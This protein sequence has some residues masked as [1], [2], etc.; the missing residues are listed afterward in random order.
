MNC[1]LRLIIAVSLSVSCGTLPL[2]DGNDKPGYRVVPDWPKLPPGYQFGDVPGVAVDSKGRVFVFHRGKNRV[3]IFESDG[4]FVSSWGDDLIEGAHHVKIDRDGYVWLSDYKAHVVHKCTADGKV[5]M[6]LGTPKVQGED[7]AHFYQPT[8]M[9][10]ASNGD[11]YVSDGYGNNRVVQFSREGKY[12]RAWEKKGRAPGEFN[13]PHAIAVDS[14]DRVYVADRSNARIQ[15]FDRSGKFL[16]L[17][18]H[19]LVPWGFFV[20]AKDEI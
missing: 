6:T 12:I 4:A 1:M 19:L 2:A 20:T 3:M 16:Y 7:A 17:W 18:D 13:L 5:L 9:A 14:R 15:V 10:F 11:I 8:D